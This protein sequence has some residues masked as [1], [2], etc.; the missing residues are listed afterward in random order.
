MPPARRKTAL[1]TIPFDGDGSAHGRDDFC[2][3][4]SGNMSRNGMVFDACF[5]DRDVY[6]SAPNSGEDLTRYFPELVEAALRLK[7]RFSWSTVR[8]SS[9]TESVFI[10]RFTATNSPRREPGQE[11]FAG[12]ARFISFDILAE[13]GAQKRLSARPLREKRPALDAFAK[14]QFKSN[15]N[16][17]TVAGAAIAKKWLARAGGGCDALIAKRLDMAYQAG[18]RKRHAEDQE[19][20]QCRLRGAAFMRRIN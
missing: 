10:R 19:F 3:A 8:S 9:R 6:C 18:N 7:P 13:R 20:S 15:P 11:T 4:R 16:V 12:N 2:A 14:S 5:Q 17:S 1:K